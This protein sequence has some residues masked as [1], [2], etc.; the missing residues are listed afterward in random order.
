MD[1]GTCVSEGCELRVHP[2]WGLQ[3]QIAVRWPILVRLVLDRGERLL[4]PLAVLWEGST[5]VVHTVRL[6]DCCLEKFRV[7]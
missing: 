3:A 5:A 2:P 7:V 1:G 4:D 6:S